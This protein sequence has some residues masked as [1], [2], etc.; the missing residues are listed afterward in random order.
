MNNKQRKTEFS[1]NNIAIAPRLLLLFLVPVAVLAIVGGMAIK[2]LNQNG[3][4]LVD[5]RYRIENI[6]RYEQL[7]NQINTDYRQ[8]LIG[9]E[10]GT[11][12]WD[13]GKHACSRPIN[14]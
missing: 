2:A 7:I 1:L 9:V 6:N 3:H 8:T 12:T 14:P 13:E 11:L 10:N 4:S 5:L